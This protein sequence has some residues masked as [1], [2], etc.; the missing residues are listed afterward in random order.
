ME[1]L[2]NFQKI[3]NEFQYFINWYLV[4]NLPEI[5]PEKFPGKFTEVFNSYQNFS[6]FKRFAINFTK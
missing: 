4:E 6:K 5:L 3:L 1:S 2:H